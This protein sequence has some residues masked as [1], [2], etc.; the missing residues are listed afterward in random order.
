MIRGEE[1]SPQERSSENC[2]EVERIDWSAHS[3]AVRRI[4]SN[5]GLIASSDAFVEV[6][7]SKKFGVNG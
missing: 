4:N 1:T 5:D 3:Q 2:Q 6:I 7:I